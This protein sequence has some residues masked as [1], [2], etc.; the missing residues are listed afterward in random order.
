MVAR[1]SP[2]VDQLELDLV[3]TTSTAVRAVNTLEVMK[4]IA[5]ARLTQLTQEA[6]DNK[7]LALAREDDWMNGLLVGAGAGLVVA[8]LTTIVVSISQ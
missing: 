7:A 8:V 4:S 6:V 5:D 1:L 3:R 2:L